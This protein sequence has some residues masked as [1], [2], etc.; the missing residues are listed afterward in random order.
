MDFV[1]A[2]R[3]MYSCCLNTN[4]NLFERTMKSI[5]RIGTVKY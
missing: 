3:A 2:F 4:E 1:T 5:V